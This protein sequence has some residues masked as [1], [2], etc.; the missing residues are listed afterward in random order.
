MDAKRPWHGTP[1]PTRDLGETQI[2]ST[3]GP[4]HWKIQ[5]FGHLAQHAQKIAVPKAFGF[6]K[7]FRRKTKSRTAI[8]T[9]DWRRQIYP[10]FLIRMIS[11]CHFCLAT[12]GSGLMPSVLCLPLSGCLSAFQLVSISSIVS[13]SILSMVSTLSNS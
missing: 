4:T 12:C 5:G 7:R 6:D 2:F 10:I 1:P 9:P 11:S 8:Y 3:K 13:I